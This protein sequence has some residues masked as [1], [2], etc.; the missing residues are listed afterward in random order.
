M[1]AFAPRP[2][3]RPEPATLER[4]E[5]L[6]VR[7]VDEPLVD[8][9]ADEPT[10][11]KVAVS[12]WAER[13]LDHETL[14]FTDTDCVFLGEPAELVE[15]DWVAAAA[16]GR[17]AD[18]RVA[19]QGQERALLAQDVRRARGRGPS[20]SCAPRSA[21]WRSAP[22]GTA[23]WSA[24][25]RSAGLFGAWERALN[26]LHD[27][28]LVFDKWPHFMD[29]LS[30]AAVTADVHDR[31]RILSD[32]YN[33]PLRHRASLAP[34]AVELDL[35]DLVHVHYRLWLHMPDAAREGEPAVRPGERPVSP[36]SPSACPSS[37]RS[38]T[39]A[40]AG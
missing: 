10:Y 23:A 5:A 15:G 29:Q 35:A 27:A 9:F 7:L 1:Y 13:E 18:R 36:G 39:R 4:L 20:R 22:T 32:A 37:R 2:G 3:F 30:L 8:R 38:R 40:R 26:Q 33:Y 11:N 25:R 14:V 28:D 31:V 6:D 19:R 24:A 21:R 16:P 34:E 12:A 17:P